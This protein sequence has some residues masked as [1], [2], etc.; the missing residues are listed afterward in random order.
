MTSK[1]TGTNGRQFVCVAGKNDIAV[2]VMEYL[3]N[4]NADFDIGIVCNKTE[5]GENSFQKSLRWFA[6]KHGVKEFLLEDLYDK[7]NVI[8]FS[9]EFDRLIKPEKFK[10]ARLYNIHFSLLPQYKGMYTSAM[11]LLNGESRSGVTLH[12]IDEGIDT[13]DIIDQ[14]A[15]SI[16]GMDCRELYHAYIKH[17]V[18][19]VLRNIK[20]IL[21]GKE[22]AY[23]QDARGSTYFSREKID[24]GNIKIDLNQT[25]E[26]V[27]RQIRAFNFREYQMPIVNDRRIIDCAITD[28]RSIQKAGTIVCE[29]EDAC[30]LC[31]IDYNIILYYDRLEEFLQY[32]SCGEMEKVRGICAVKKHINSSDEHGWTPL[33]VATYHNQIEVAKYLIAQGADIH[34]VN[35][36][37]TTLLMYAK[38]AY[39]RTKDGRLFMLY[40]SL[41]ADVHQKDYYGKTLKQYCIEE[42]IQHIAD[43]NIYEEKNIPNISGGVKSC[44]KEKFLICNFFIIKLRKYRIVCKE[45]A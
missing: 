35:H 4:V 37:G 29:T 12:R 26:G 19:V 32:C 31:T 9:M 8:F 3:L 38:E 7:D 34:A 43:Y 18:E 25:A 16:E 27:A 10:D 14:Q 21:A 17:G 33:I 6:K 39:K 41:G 1:K 22:K 13:G 36:Y 2:E 28:I 40:V 5:T 45:A 44:R 20:E 42:G 11:P 15:F 23:P 24:Y 30:V